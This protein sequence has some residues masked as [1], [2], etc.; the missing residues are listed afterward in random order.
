MFLA[1][2]VIHCH[3]VL[4]IH[5]LNTNQMVLPTWFRFLLWQRN[6]TAGKTPLSH[7]CNDIAADRTDIKIYSLHVGGPVFI[8]PQVPGQQFRNR[9]TKRQF[10]NHTDIRQPFIR[11]PF[12]NSLIAYM[13][14]FCKLFLGKLPFFP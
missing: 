5:S 2:L 1:H 12:R 3:E 8:Y 6:P 9:H 11:F 4:I 7:S 14:D 10:V 13:D